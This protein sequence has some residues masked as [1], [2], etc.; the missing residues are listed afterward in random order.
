MKKI[1]SRTLIIVLL[2]LLMA[3]LI[4]TVLAKET[5]YGPPEPVRFASFNASLNRFNAG[6]LIED[7]STPDNGQA[8][9]VA[10]IIQRTRPDVLLIN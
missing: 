4:P 6:D 5:Q 10:E 7:L 8:K 1:N 9:A 2:L 3:L